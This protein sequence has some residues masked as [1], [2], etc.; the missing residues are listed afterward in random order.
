M[1]NYFIPSTFSSNAYEIGDTV[2]LTARGTNLKVSGGEEEIE[3]ESGPGELTLT[4]PGTYTV[5]QK[6]MV[7]DSN[8]IENFFV[9]I[10]VSE[11]DISKEVD[12]LP[13]ISTDTTTSVGYRDLLFYFALALVA[14]MFVEWVLQIK[15]NF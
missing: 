5:T 6:P 13:I 10:P 7:G 1:F 9:R 8:I 15:K 11:S 14:L 12:E 4:T 2:E 3:Y